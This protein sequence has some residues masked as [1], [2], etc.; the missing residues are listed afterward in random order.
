M[1]IKTG[2]REQIVNFDY[3]PYPD[4]SLV[5]YDVYMKFRNEAAITNCITIQGTRGC[6]FECAYCH[7]IWPKKH[8]YRTAENLIDEIQIYYQMGVK[9]FAFIDDVFNLNRENSMRFFD[10]LIKKSIKIDIFFPNGVRGDILDKAYIDLMVEAGVVYLAMALETASERLQKLVG[11]NLNIDKLHDNLSYL[12]Q[13]YPQIITVLFMMVGFPTETED[14]A[15]KTLNFIKSIK[16]IHFPRLHALTI[17][18]NTEMEKIALQHGVLKESIDASLSGF[19]YGS[20][21]TMPFKNSH[22][23]TELRAILLKDYW[24]NKERLNYVLPGQVKHLTEPELLA[25]YNDLF[26][27]HFNNLGE[28]LRFF[29]LKQTMITDDFRQCK[30]DDTIVVKQIRPKM[31]DYFGRK[32]QSHNASKILFLDVTA[33]FSLS[34][35][36]A[37]YYMVP[38]PLGHMYLATYL[39]TVLKDQVTCKLCKPVVDYNNYDELKEIIVSFSPD[40][41]AVR[42]MSCYKEIFQETVS[43]IRS[44]GYWQPIIVGGPH[45]TSCYNE[46]LTENEVDLVILGEGELTFTEVIRAIINN[47]NKMPNES[48]LLHINGI[49]FTDGIK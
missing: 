21:L 27:T 28:L 36:K 30:S 43:R 31:E 37:A 9:R 45:A 39:K 44:W 40:I 26:R 20:P 12:C 42:C 19:Y 25:I 32:E 49:C 29:R 16:W 11:K 46:I 8:V 35:E 1:I 47:Q 18:P 14:E 2:K 41:F 3:I 38:P 7:K 10:L 4:R 23:L 24:L 15:F 22:F 34:K 6:P 13:K 17:Y 48:E 5:D 33:D